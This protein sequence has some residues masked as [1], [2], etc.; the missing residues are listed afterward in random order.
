MSR[1]RTLFSGSGTNPATPGNISGYNPPTGGTLAGYNPPV[2]GNYAGTNPADPGNVAGYNPPISVLEYNAEG[3]QYWSTYNNIYGWY[4]ETYNSWSSGGEGNAPSPVHQHYFS[5]G[6]GTQGQTFYTSY[7]VV[8]SSAGYVTNPGNEYYNPGSPGTPY[9][10][11]PSP[12]T[13]YYNPTTPGNAK[14]NPSIP[15][16][17]I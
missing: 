11:P 15:G 14:Y 5:N 1:F 10:N 6:G 9:Y 8:Y 13:A 2:Q 17:H 3:S 7:D 12:G 4:D 16:Y